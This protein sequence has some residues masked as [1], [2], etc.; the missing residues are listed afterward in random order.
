MTGVVFHYNRV[1]VIVYFG[2]TK[3]WT[4]SVVVFGIHGKKNEFCEHPYEYRLL[5]NNLTVA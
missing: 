2:Q 3:K 5:D 4:E 1:K